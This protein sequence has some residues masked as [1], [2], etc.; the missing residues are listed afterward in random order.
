MN[1]LLSLIKML[2][3]LGL[4]LYGMKLLSTNLKKLSGG[5]LEEV[6]V[7]A[8][9]NPLKGL[10]VGFLTTVMT[11]SSAT[12]TVLVVGLVNS[13]ILSLKNA[14]PIIMGANIGTTINSQILRLAGLNGNNLLS[15]ISPSTLAPILLLVS[16]MIG[17]RAKKQKTRYYAEMLFGL[18]LLFTGMIT[19]V[20]M[21]ST[22][23]EIKALQ[24]I[25]VSLKNPILG[26]LIG[27][28]VTAIV[29]SSS[30]TIGIL[31]AFST[32][33]LITY[34]TTIPIILGQ[35]I[36]T[37]VT[38]IIASIGGNTNAKRIALVHLLFN[39][40]GTIFFVIIIY[41]YQEILGFSFWNE[42]I[43]MGG[44]ANF[45]LIFNVVSTIL[46]FPF[47]NLLEKLT[48]LI[49]QE[50]KEEDDDK[51]NY[52][53]SLE[54]LD[55]RIELI[56]RIAISNCNDVVIKMAELALKNFH[57]TMY[58]LEK[59]DS[60]SLMKI[61]A[62]ENKI[63]KMEEVVTKYLVNLESLDLS[64]KQNRKITT[65]L[66]VESEFEKIGDYAYRISKMIEN[67]NEEEIVLSKIARK[68]INAMQDATTKCIEETITLLNTKKI[69]NSINVS[70]LR[71]W[72]DIQKEK[73]K[74]NHL[75]RLKKEEC[76]VE[77]GIS[78]IEILNACDSI[79][80]HCLNISI[81]ISSYAINKNV[82]TKHDYREY[83][84]KN[85]E[86]ELK[87]ALKNYKKIA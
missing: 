65:L 40:I 4:L 30:A 18:G 31:Q 60:K 42:T 35:N 54:K 57:K 51:D 24:N 32:T 79:A 26:I 69:E 62:R 12:T 68:E 23:G 55:N 28:M 16:L 36:G 52:L 29:Q 71:E 17:S 53:A 82:I 48:C 19:M 59:Y 50:K 3:G 76:T 78:F 20:N 83:M 39:L 64:E 85:Y 27:G 72:I 56:P 33:G 7:T 75:E 77:C 81:S 73:Y 10:L 21:A 43:T 84:R 22:F 61:E 58:L 5:K 9:S 70:A 11:Q 44:I 87:E 67:M 46:L 86:K 34:Q 80:N 63:D 15:L 13:E 1:I 2:G 8:T 74:D 25:L 6:L 66:R 14:I 45:H 49:I 41:T 38:S 47:L 37:C